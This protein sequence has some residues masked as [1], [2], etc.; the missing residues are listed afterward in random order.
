MNG[1]E[2]FRY[3]SVQGEPD[4]GTSALVYDCARE[5]AVAASEAYTYSLVPLRLD[6]DVLLNGRY[7]IKSRDLAAHLAECDKCAVFAAT[8]GASAEY[9]L[10]RYGRTNVRRAVVMHACAAAQIEELCNRMENEISEHAKA[11]GLFL[12]PRF[13]PGYGD[14]SLEHQ[15]DIAALTQC[16]SRIGVGVTESL[17]LTPSK[18]VTGIIG[19]SKIRVPASDSCSSCRMHDTCDY[20]RSGPCCK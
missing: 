10:Y 9:L 2:I 3:L 6:G 1:S 18:S 12:R 5:L 13:S 16:G 15:Q 7:L 17:L 11:E 19:F 20:R 14:F 4:P 8:L